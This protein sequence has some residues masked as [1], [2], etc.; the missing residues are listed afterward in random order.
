MGF[1]QHRDDFMAQ[2]LAQVSVFRDEVMDEQGE[3]S[4][5]ADHRAIDDFAVLAH[6]HIAALIGIEFQSEA[7]V[8]GVTLKRPRS[9]TQNQASWSC[10]KAWR[11]RLWRVKAVGVKKSEL[12]ERLWT[13]LGICRLQ[14]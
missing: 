14:Y 3:Q 9:C 6:E 8:Q 13:Q 5:F 4:G 2:P 10:M 12:S 7:F 1:A 11:K